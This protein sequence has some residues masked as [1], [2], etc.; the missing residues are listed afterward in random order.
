M[1]AALATIVLTAVSGLLEAASVAVGERAAERVGA[2]LRT[3]AFARSLQL[4]LAWH[5]RVR[6]GGSSSHG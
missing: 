3:D 2:R 1:L 5:A 4:S 6:R